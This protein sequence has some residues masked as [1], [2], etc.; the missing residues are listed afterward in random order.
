MRISERQEAS[1]VKAIEAD[2]T[3]SVLVSR[4]KSSHSIYFEAYDEADDERW[5]LVVRISN[6]GSFACLR[7]PDIDICTDG[8]KWSDIK[9]IVLDKVAGWH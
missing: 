2:G 5:P 6:H 7:Q 1:L 9:S 8:L 3:L 4:S